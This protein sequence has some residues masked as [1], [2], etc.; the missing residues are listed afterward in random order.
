MTGNP[1]TFRGQISRLLLQKRLSLGMSQQSLGLLLGYA[2]HLAAAAIERWESGSKTV[3]YPPVPYYREVLANFLGM[4]V[5]DLQDTFV[6][7]SRKRHSW[8]AHSRKGSN[9]PETPKVFDKLRAVLLEAQE[10]VPPEVEHPTEGRLSPRALM[11]LALMSE[12]VH[13]KGV[14]PTAVLRL[15]DRLAQVESLLQPLAG[16]VHPGT[17]RTAG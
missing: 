14:S 11:L 4:T 13:F 8:K 7:D 15:M 3:R 5:V 9:T 6:L 17:S 12:D 1:E 16:G 2:P 10:V